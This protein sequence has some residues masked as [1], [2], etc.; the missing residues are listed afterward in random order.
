M[1]RVSSIGRDFCLIMTGIAL[2][3]ICVETGIITTRHDQLTEIV[4]AGSE[5]TITTPEKLPVKK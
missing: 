2:W 4:E 5:V 1:E 3:L